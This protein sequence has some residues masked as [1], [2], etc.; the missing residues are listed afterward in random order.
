MGRDDFWIGVGA[1]ILGAGIIA[2]ALS[3]LDEE[4]YKRGWNGD[5]LASRNILGIFGWTTSGTFVLLS[6][7][8]RGR[9]DREVKLS[10]TA[11]A[12]RIESIVQQGRYVINRLNELEQESK[13]RPEVEISL[14]EK[15]FLKDLHNIAKDRLAHPQPHQS[16]PYVA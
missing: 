13:K 8:N 16:R 7:F 2:Y 12:S 4:S 15:K 1:G 9:Y 3:K 6:S 10:L 14:E 11:Q 5:E